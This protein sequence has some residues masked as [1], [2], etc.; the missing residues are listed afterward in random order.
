LQIAPTPAAA[1][2][3]PAAEASGDEEALLAILLSAAFVD[4]A[5]AA[6]S[7]PTATTAE[8]A[9]DD[10]PD[11]ASALVEQRKQQLRDFYSIHDASKLL[12]SDS[13]LQEL[14]YES[15]LK[16]V[17][18]KYGSVPLGW[19]RDIGATWISESEAQQIRDVHPK[20]GNQWVHLA[21]LLPGRTAKNVMTFWNSARN[22]TWA[23]AAVPPKPKPTKA[24][25]V[26][27][28]AAA[29]SAMELTQLQLEDNG[30]EI[31]KCKHCEGIGGLDNSSG[32]TVCTKGSCMLEANLVSKCSQCEDG[33]GS[34]NNSSAGKV[35]GKGSCMFAAG[36]VS[37]CKH[38]EDG[39]GSFDNGSRWI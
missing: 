23:T 34:L 38:C 17:F 15:V 27:V 2:P 19:E 4:T 29:A 35:C 18:Q 6:D 7:P 31:Q 10:A 1:D 12:I 13:L 26:A 37:K 25:T 9:Q 3:T 30:R 28:I 8:V 32:G 24:A 36:L 16:A 22:R 21:R 14:G 33:I 39:F 11:S 20:I 5:A